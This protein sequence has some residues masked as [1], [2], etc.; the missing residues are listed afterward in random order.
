MLWELLQEKADVDGEKEKDMEKQRTLERVKNW[1]ELSDRMAQEIATLRGRLED[2]TEMSKEVQM[3]RHE[4]AI[5]RARNAEHEAR[6]SNYGGKPPV[7]PATKGD[8]PRAAFSSGNWI[9]PGGR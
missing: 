5:L 3:L 7:D 6:S 1:L 8:A 2:Q 9:Y 4:V